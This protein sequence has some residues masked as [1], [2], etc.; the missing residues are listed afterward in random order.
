M[1]SAPSLCRHPSSRAIF[2]E[3]DAVERLSGRHHFELD[4]VVTD[5][6]SPSRRAR[7][8]LPGSS[9]RHCRSCRRSFGRIL[10]RLAVKI[11]H[12]LDMDV[13]RCCAAEHLDLAGVDRVVAQDVDDDVEPLAG[14]IPTDRGRAQDQRR[15]PARVL[16]SAPARTAALNFR[17]VGQRFERQLLGDVVLVLD[18]VDARGR[19]IKRALPRLFRGFD[20]GPEAVVIVTCAPQR[21]IELEGRVVGNAGEMDDGVSQPASAF[22]TTAV[23]H[24]ALDL[25]ELRMV[26]TGFRTS[27]P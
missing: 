3:R 27:S 12:V 5:D 13:K 26:S 15:E 11:A 14:R 16:R 23:P 20:E 1:S 21:R 10:Q 24:V 2:S 7:A 9:S 25:D 18:A 8:R 4:R 17:I 19:G 6:A 22:S